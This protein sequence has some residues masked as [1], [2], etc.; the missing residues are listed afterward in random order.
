M[1]KFSTI[2]ISLYLSHMEKIIMSHKLYLLL[3]LC[4][5]LYPDVVI[6]YEK[7]GKSE[8]KFV[9][10]IYI[11]TSNLGVHFK[12]PGRFGR[13]KNYLVNCDDV[14]SVF[15]DNEKPISLDCMNYT[16]NEK[17]VL[18]Q[19]FCIYCE[20]KVEF[21]KNLPLCRICESKKEKNKL[22]GT[23]CHKCGKKHESSEE[24]PM[25]TICNIMY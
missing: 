22:V 25:C 16:H 24:K 10:V 19:A 4:S 20:G 13:Y 14:K 11:G 12:K 1:N 6:L 2:L 21:D 18:E 9:G 15:D 8:K 17:V 23:T 5:F 3:F 7:G